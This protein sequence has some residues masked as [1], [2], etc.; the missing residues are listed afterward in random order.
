M[1]PEPLTDTG[2][3]EGFDPRGR[4]RDDL[5]GA[6]ARLRDLG[7]VVYSRQLQAWCVTGHEDIAAILRN[8]ADFSARDH[9]PRP[10]LDLP[11]DV[12]EILRTWS[13]DSASLGEM[14]PPEHTRVRS[15]INAGFTP[16]ALQPAEADIRATA[17]Q[18]LQPL[19]EVAEFDLVADFA[20][21]YALTVILR[22]L[23]IPEEH[24]QD[25]LRWSDH[26]VQL[27]VGRDHTPQQLRECATGLRDFGAFARE[28]TA[29]RLA[30]P[31]E[32]LISTMLHESPHGHRLTPEEVAALIPTLIITGHTTLAQG[33]AITVRHQLR[34]PGG[35]TAVV[36]GRVSIPH[37]VEEGLRLD[38]PVVGMYRTT[39][40]EVTVAGQVLP[41]GS[42]VLLLYG[43][44]N[45]DPGRYPE[46]DHC[47]PE[48]WPTA[49]H[50]AF[51]RGTHYCAGA[52]LARAELRI[53][54]EELAAR[55]PGLSAASEAGPVYRPTF[56][57]RALTALRVRP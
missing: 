43:A 36:D 35:W 48:R 52:G 18:L 37:L 10:T 55:F 47:R 26:K 19:T 28:L 39:V 1:A 33:L 3:P 15:V 12:A 54:L 22:F 24:H 30:E 7:E 56:P 34:S 44:A 29:R 27:M 21:P 41:A 13:G 53:A 9:K 23:G 25:C 51:G 31:R 17:V 57:L 42:K 20:L 40:R 4:D 38:C 49:A 14:D 50:L 11:P 16:W 45:H 32:D 46:P 6:L 5:Y 2:P 8:D